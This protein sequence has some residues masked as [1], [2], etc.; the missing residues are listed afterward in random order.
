MNIIN[1]TFC[2]AN[3][4]NLHGK[5]VNLWWWA[6]PISINKVIEVELLH[7][8]KYL[9]NLAVSYTI[10]MSHAGFRLEAGLFGYT[11]ELQIYDS[12]HWDYEKDD[13]EDE[14]SETHA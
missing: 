5:F 2:L 9:V 6:R 14:Y 8:P 13:W 12:R 10:R 7:D 1:L 11:L 4:F 3:I